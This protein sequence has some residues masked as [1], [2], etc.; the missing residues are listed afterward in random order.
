M[1]HPSQKIVRIGFR[2][3]GSYAQFEPV[4]PAFVE[5][6]RGVPGLVWKIWTYDEGSGRGAGLYLFENEA[7]ARAYLAEMLP[8]M[9][10]MV[11]ELDPQV[12]DFHL[13][14]TVGTRGPVGDRL[15]A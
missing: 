14:A 11:E 8:A 1:N 12:L 13:A 10:T 15:P 3:R 4:L 7:A 2:Y 6:L 9:A 5:R